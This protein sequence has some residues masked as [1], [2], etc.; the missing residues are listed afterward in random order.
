MRM[1]PTRRA[2]TARKGTARGRRL[3]RVSS[4]R[5]AFS[6]EVRK[7]EDTSAP[8]GSA[9]VRPA[10]DHEHAAYRRERAGGGR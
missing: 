7:L 5:L 2:R 10:A 4:G 3:R 1:P 9:M 6:T 8:Y